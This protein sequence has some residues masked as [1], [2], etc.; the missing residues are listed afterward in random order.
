[1]PAVAVNPKDER[2]LAIAEGDAYGGGCSLHVSTDRG[3]SWSRAST[4]DIPERWSKCVFQSVGVVADA[5]FGPDGTLYYGFNGFDP[6]SSEGQVFLARSKDLGK[7]WVTTG[8]PRIERDRDKGE[9]GLDAIPSIA[10]DPDNPQHVY[11]AWVSNYGTWRLRGEVLQG[12]EFF[13][14]IVMR[15]YIASSTDGGKSFSAPVNLAENLASKGDV[16]QLKTPPRALVGNDGEVYV[17]FGE[18]TRAGTREAPDGG[19]PPPPSVYLAV[20]RDGGKTY[21]GRSTTPSRAR[22]TGKDL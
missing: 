16:E 22:S 21:Q 11:V 18:Q 19:V 15:P 10:I 9:F 5:A 8:L 6:V 20:S 2:V 7:T 12:K 17:V 1:M 14:D 4:P 3:L 13:Y